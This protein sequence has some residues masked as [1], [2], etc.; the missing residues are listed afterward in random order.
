MFRKVFDNVYEVDV[1]YPELRNTFASYVLLGENVLIIDPGPIN[2]HKNLINDLESMGVSRSDKIYVALTHIHPDHYG[3]ASK[4]VEF[5]PDSLVLV[6]P[7]GA[8]HLVNVDY[9]WDSAKMVLGEIA[10][11]FGKPEPIPRDKIVELHDNYEINV[12]ENNSVRALFTPG[13]ATHHVSYF[14]ESDKVVFLGDAG[15]LYVGDSLAPTTPF[16]FNFNKAIDS[17]MRILSL[18]PYYVAYTHFGMHGDAIKRLLEYVGQL[19]I[20][21]KISQQKDPN[22]IKPDELLEEILQFDYETRAFM[23]KNKNNPVLSGAVHHSIYGFIKY[24]EYIREKT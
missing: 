4:L 13:H 1:G 10:S 3:A 16:P 9:L 17:I 11:I 22:S 6:H 7:R 20:W 14:L 2:F 18:E 24:I 12:S 5:Y 8:R 15:G 21:F 19:Y 23:E